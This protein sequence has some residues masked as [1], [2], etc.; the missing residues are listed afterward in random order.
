MPLSDDEQGLLR[1]LQTRLDRDKKD[2]RRNGHR[3]PGFESLQAYYD[4]FQRLEQLG[5]AVPEQLRDFVVI[6]AWPQTYVD[7]IVTRLRPQGFLLGGQIDEQLW[8]DWQVNNLDTEIRMG[9]TDMLKFGRGYTCTGVHAERDDVPL[10]TVESP[11]QMIHAWSNRERRITAAARF[12]TEDTGGRRPERRATLYQANKTTWLVRGRNGWLEDGKPDE[13]GLGRVPV[14]VLINRASTDDRYGRSEM[15]PIIGLTNAAARALTNAQIATELLAVPQRHAAGLKPEDFKD[16]KTKE[17]LTTWEAYFGAIW[18]SSNSEARFGQF[19]AA[20]LA[21]FRTI[22]STYAQM[23]SGSTGL[24]MRYFGQLSDN[25]PSADGI[26]ADESRLVGTAEEKQLFADAG[27]EDTMRT[28]RQIV[29]GEADPKMA[30]LETWWRS[31]NTPTLA[32]AADAAVKLYS[33]NVISRRQALRDM[34]YTPKQIEQILDDL[35][36]DANDDP[37]LAALARGGGPGAAA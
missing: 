14:N 23:C 22:V 17:Q 13:H 32:A 20:D 21:N 3:I 36:A 30:E 16:P 12:Y 10:H 7:A 19:A 8:T 1:R 33:Q 18:A 4:G 11:L 34:G 2:T 31:A 5:I 26:R 25:P 37:V 15:L 35:A 29:T 24:P 6:V 27:L 28:G 9:L